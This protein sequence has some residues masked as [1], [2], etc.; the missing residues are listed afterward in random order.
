MDENF[1]Q[2]ALR[3]WR[4]AELLKEQNRVDNAD[5]LYGFAA[6]CAIKQ[7]LLHLPA[8]ANH[9]NLHQPYK[10]HIDVLWNKVGHQSLQKIYPGLLAYIKN[11]GKPFD[12][13]KVEQRYSI[14]NAI[15]T[16]RM[17]AHRAAT[18]ELFKSTHLPKR[19]K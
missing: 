12:D 1:T 9:G 2:A 7:A 16:H 5:Q 14:D 17:H 18:L 8:F 15:P 11:G 13:W 4:D 3:H 6:E 10:E 19:R